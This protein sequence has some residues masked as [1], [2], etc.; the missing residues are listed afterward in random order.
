MLK[1]K[2]FFLTQVDNKQ[3]RLDKALEFQQRYQDVLQNVSNWLDV[4]EQKLFA[5][6]SGMTAEE[7][8]KENEVFIEKHNWKLN[9][10]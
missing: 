9:K 10:I 7:K 2:N 4:T 3:L 6:D 5:P 8:V 1:F